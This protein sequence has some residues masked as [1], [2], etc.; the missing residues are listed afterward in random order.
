MTDIL[1][2]IF[3]Q[4]ET[5]QPLPTPQE[6]KQLT[7]NFWRPEC[8]S[9]YWEEFLKELQRRGINMDDLGPANPLP[10][11]GNHQSSE[12]HTN[13]RTNMGPSTF[14]ST[15]NAV[16]NFDGDRRI[17]SSVQNM[18]K[19]LSTKVGNKFLEIPSL[20]QRIDGS[21]RGLKAGVLSPAPAP[22]PIPLI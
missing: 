5:G 15:H 7:D 14:S 19:Q 3:E 13:G 18:L 1:Q 16:R 10:D 8:K 11:T 4:Q 6:R 2:Y 17:R 20:L 21:V 12:E 9:Y 22:K